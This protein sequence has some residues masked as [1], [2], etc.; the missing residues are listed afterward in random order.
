[1]NNI[2]LNMHKFIDANTFE[3]ISDENVIEVDPD[4]AL[5]V[6]LLNKKG[7][8]TKACCSGHAFDYTYTKQVCDISLLNEDK[9]KEDYPEYYIVDKNENSFVFI[10][11]KLATRI[12]IKFI[13]DY[14]F[15]SLPLGFMKEPSFDDHLMDWSKTNFDSISKVIDYYENN[16]KRNPNDVQKDIEKY[17]NLL[18][19]WVKELP[20]INERNDE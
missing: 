18:L 15:E 7:Y 14:H 8:F 20:D 16:K 1:M 6:S 17:N 5:A 10:T 2:N 19:E 4:I 3:V 11:P 12:Y 9:I 13:K